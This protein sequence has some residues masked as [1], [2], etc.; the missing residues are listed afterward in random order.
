VP[1]LSVPPTA[2]DTW[3]S[4]PEERADF[5]PCDDLI[6]SSHPLFRAIDIDAPAPLVFRWLCQMRVAPYSYDWI[7][8]FG[9]RSPQQL[10]DGLDD[11][12]VGQRFMIFRLVSFEPGRSITLESTSPWFG[13]VAIT[14]DARPVDPA[15]CRLVAKVLFV[16]PRNFYGA[17]MQRILPAGDL[18]MMRRQ[19]LNFRDLAE[20]DARALVS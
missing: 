11:L 5:Y 17:V 7:D 2:I 3:G 16:A 15:Q 10:V 8:N 14:Y 9:R 12:E 6:E 19:L 13:H 1:R 18:V 4:T 20:R